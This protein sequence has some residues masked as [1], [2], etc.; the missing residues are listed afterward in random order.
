MT[1]KNEHLKHAL[2]R[3][4]DPSFRVHSFIGETSEIK[5][6]IIDGTIACWSGPMVAGIPV[7]Y[8]A[9]LLEGEWWLTGVTHPH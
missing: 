9:I 1:N 7:C 4:I 5:G 6:A 3:E 8:E 2:L